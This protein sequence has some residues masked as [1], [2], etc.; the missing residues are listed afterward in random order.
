MRYKSFADML[1]QISQEV[2][3]KP[4][5]LFDDDGRKAISWS[6]FYQQ[7]LARRKVLQTSRETCIGILAENTLACMIELFAANM[8]GKQIVM[9]DASAPA[10]VLVPQMHATEIDALWGNELRVKELTPF[11]TR[12]CILGERK[13]LF[14]TSGTTSSAKAVVLSDETLLQSAWN[15]SDLL[16]LQSED[17]LL[18]ILP[19]HHVFGFVCGLLWG[20]TNKACVAL[21][22]GPRHI[23]DDLAFYQPTA[24]SLVPM[25]V[26]FFYQHH[27]FN[28]QL[29]LILVGAGDC[30]EELFHAVKAMGIRV[31]F[32]YGL[33]E[34]SSGVAL[35]VGEDPLAMSVCADD[36]ITIAE[37]REILIQAPTCM[38]LGYYKRPE[39][40]AAVLQNGI[41]HTGDLGFLDEDGK[42]HITGRKKEMLVLPDGTKIFLPDYER[43][44]KKILNTDELAVVLANNA[45]VLV[46][47][48]WKEKEESIVK[49]LDTLMKTLPRGHQLSLIVPL[50]HPLPR[51]ATG[52]IKHWEIQK[53]IQEQ[54]HKEKK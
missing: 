8:A 54:W 41:L 13:I 20:M 30:S 48:E 39:D 15:G 51:T 10:A 50:H 18:D 14:F 38:M 45:P 31:A 19:L 40:T 33:S 46:V 44:L 35:A 49:A 42:L 6:D 4:V 12:G 17:I 47:N 11:L 5:F 16:P 29:H 34:T 26:S 32:G 9:L 1:E 24:V 37:D 53:E 22:R 28:P 36:T 2:P 3:A 27:L 7:V 52:K 43:P 25:L 23:L 21:G